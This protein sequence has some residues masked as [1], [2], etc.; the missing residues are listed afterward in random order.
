MQSRMSAKHP[1]EIVKELR[2]DEDFRQ[3]V[4]GAILMGKTLDTLVSKAPVA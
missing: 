2:K 4:L 1:D 3:N